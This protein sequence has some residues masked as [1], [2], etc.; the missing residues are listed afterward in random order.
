MASPKD[1]LGQL[2]SPAQAEILSAVGADAWA[3]A[4]SAFEALAG[5]SA[6]LDGLTARLVMPEEISDEFASGHLVLPLTLSTEGQQSAVAYAVADTAAAAAFF[7]SASDEEAAQEQQ[8]IVLGSSMLLQVMLALGRTV[9]ARGA[10]GLDVTAGEVTPNAMPGILAGIDEPALALNGT[11]SLARPLPFMLVLPGTFL[12]LL[13]SAM[14]GRTSAGIAHASAGGVPPVAAPVAVSSHSSGDAG[15][16]PA[17]QREPTPIA[18]APAAHRARFAPLPD[19][20]PMV[21]RQGLDLLAGLDMRICV[22]LGRTEL[23]VSEVLAL[24]AGSVIELDRLAGEPVDI[25]VND[26][27]IARGEVVVVDENF[28]VRVVEV[29]RRGHDRE[30]A[31][32]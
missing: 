16:D 17:P 23:T 10:N 32:A 28:G 1:V 22:E 18:S 4:S 20:D 13:A 25:L 19:P 5:A 14:A 3:A 21:T 15:P 24:G 8:T 2:L 11:L 30:E 27:L 7:D 6:T 31:S 26:R 9:L 12:D 29:I